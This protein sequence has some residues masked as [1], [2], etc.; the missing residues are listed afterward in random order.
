MADLQSSPEE[1]RV[2]LKEL[3]PVLQTDRMTVEQADRGAAMIRDGIVSMGGDPSDKE[4]LEGA[5]MA[6]WFALKI[7]L[8]FPVPS[9]AQN[10]WYQTEILRRMID[11]EMP[12]MSISDMLGL[13]NA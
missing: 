5:M 3:G 7:T 6:S 11:G 12:I 13:S 2:K 9:L 1:M 10:L 4:L 8:L